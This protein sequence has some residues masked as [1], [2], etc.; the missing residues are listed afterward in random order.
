LSRWAPLFVSPHGTGCS[1]Y[2]SLLRVGDE[3]VAQWQQGQ[4]DGSQPLVSHRLP[5]ARVV[6]LLGA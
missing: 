6:A 3:L 1:R 4:P 5:W 2:L